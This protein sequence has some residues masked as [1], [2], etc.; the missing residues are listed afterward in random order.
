M[1]LDGGTS[2]QLMAGE[3]GTSPSKIV[4]FLLLL[5]LQGVEVLLQHFPASSGAGQGV[6]HLQALT[7][8]QMH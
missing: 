4:I 2:M 8:T 5:F 1:V 6:S 7:L 3:A